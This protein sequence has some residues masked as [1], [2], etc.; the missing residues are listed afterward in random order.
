MHAVEI[1]N[2]AKSRCRIQDA[3]GREVAQLDPMRLHLLRRLGTIVL[4]RST[5]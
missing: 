5:R 2:F 3:R 1:E 4:W